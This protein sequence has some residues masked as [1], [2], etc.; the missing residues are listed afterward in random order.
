MVKNNFFS[1]LITVIVTAVFSGFLTILLFELDVDVESIAGCISASMACFS[2]ILALLSLTFVYNEYQKKQKYERN[3][4]L[5]RYNERYEKSEHIQKVVEY[6]ANLEAS[7]PSKREIAS[8]TEQNTQEAK[9]VSV[10]DREMFLRFYEELYHMIETGYLDKY[11]VVNYFGYYFKI[12]WED[13]SFWIGLGDETHIE[14]NS[15]KKMPEWSFAK[16]FYNIVKKIE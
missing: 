12:A 14:P 7:S 2:F 4:V 15:V 9:T 8:K 5:M 3:E 11:L 16:S 13:N 10:N 6:Y 1:Y